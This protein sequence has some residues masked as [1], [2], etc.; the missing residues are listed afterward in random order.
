MT[1]VQKAHAWLVEPC[2]QAVCLRAGH[3]RTRRGG[4]SIVVMG[5]SD[6]RQ[7]RQSFR[8]GLR[9]IQITLSGVNEDRAGLRK[10][11]DVGPE[12]V[13]GKEKTLLPADVECTEAFATRTGAASNLAVHGMAAA[14]CTKGGPDFGGDVA[15][16]GSNNEACHVTLAVWEVQMIGA[17]RAASYPKR[18]RRKTLANPTL[19]CVALSAK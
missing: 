10:L 15:T 1:Q 3:E 19:M 13:V 9:G 5:L 8:V 7:A 14:R 4:R 12:R 18:A 16:N 17:R 6:N 2:T 11:F